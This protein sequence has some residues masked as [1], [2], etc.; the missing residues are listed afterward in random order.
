MNPTV[1]KR[2]FTALC[3]AGAVVGSWAAGCA[4]ARN[5]LQQ[6]TYNELKREELSSERQEFIS[7]TQG[8]LATVTNDMD[9]LRAKLEH[10]SPYVDKQQRSAWSQELFEL[11]QERDRLRGELSRAQ[12]ASAAEW[13]QMRGPIGVATDSLQARVSKI[14]ISLAGSSTR[15]RNSQ[16]PFPTRTESGLCPI[17]VDGVEASVEKQDRT[18]VVVVTTG[19]SDFVP[20]LQARAHK[21][22]TLDSYPLTDARVADRSEAPF[23]TGGFDQAP[24]AP[25]PLA[26]GTAA[27]VPTIPVKITVE[28]VERGAKLVF[29]PANDKLVELE[30]RLQTDADRLEEGLC[31]G[32]NEVSL[33]QHH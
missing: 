14:G 16:N 20:A 11:S 30:A 19:T 9:L 23:S 17:R 28:N 32:P 29:A 24:S 13:E 4:S 15:G 18:L 25:A 21:M 26:H 33:S 3:L 10:E 8:R 5:N 2:K 12:T 27:P 1:G 31:R 22:S 7:D 6:P